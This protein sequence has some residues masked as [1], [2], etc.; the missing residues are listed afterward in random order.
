[1]APPP[2]KGSRCRQ[3]R[4]SRKQRRRFAALHI[5]GLGALFA[6]AAVAAL[7]RVRAG[8]AHGCTGLHCPCKSRLGHGLRC[9]AV[10]RMRVGCQG[11]A[12]TARLTAK[13][14]SQAGAGQARNCRRSYEQQLASSKI[15]STPHPASSKLTCCL[16][17]RRQGE[18]RGGVGHRQ[19]AA[20]TPG[21]CSQGG[22]RGRASWWPYTNGCWRAGA[23]A[24]DRGHTSCTTA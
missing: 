18:A 13:S 3:G 2:P 21:H 9:R 1:M 11:H 8:G 20:L 4:P 6:A 5:A 22:R 23:G 14:G 16:W 7:S 24:A 10:G 12:C 17:Q 15:A 19:G